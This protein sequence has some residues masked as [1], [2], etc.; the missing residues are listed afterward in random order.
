MSTVKSKPKRQES[1]PPA[2]AF[3]GMKKAPTEDEIEASLGSAKPMWDQIIASLGSE[4]FKLRD[5]EWNCPAPK[6]GWS[7]RLKR[8]GRNIIY[9]VPIGGAFR[10]AFVLGKKAIAAALASDLPYAVKRV[11]KDAPV[12]PEGTGVRFEVRS[13]EDVAFVVKLARLKLEN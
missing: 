3:V 11:I 2:N 7:L 10:V 1:E 13:S 5:H 8:A 9:L 6:Y 12:Y 4:E